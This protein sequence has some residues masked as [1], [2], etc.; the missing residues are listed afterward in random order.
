M[1]D[2]T[3]FE[4]SCSGLILSFTYKGAAHSCQRYL[5]VSS[6]RVDYFSIVAFAFYFS[7]HVQLPRENNT[8]AMENIIMLPQLRDNIHQFKDEQIMA[9]PCYEQE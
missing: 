2:G 3:L 8:N 5:H 9:E 6:N 1:N 7:N 4:L